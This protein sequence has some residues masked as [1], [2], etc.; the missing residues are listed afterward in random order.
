MQ[1][2]ETKEQALKA[3]QNR[4]KLDQLPKELLKQYPEICMEAVK[5]RWMNLKYVPEEVKKAHP[6]ICIEAMKQN[7]SALK[8]WPE[9]VQKKYLEL[10]QQAVKENG[11]LLEYLSEEIKKAHPD[12]CIE[13]VKQNNSALEYMPEEVQK[14]HPE[15]CQQ[16]VKEDGSLLKYVPEEVKKTH[17]DICAEAVK[18]Y[19][20]AIKYVPEEVQ[21]K[22]TELCGQAVK[23]DGELLEYISEEVKKTHPE[24]CLEA[25]KQSGDL[26]KYVPKDVMKQ[27]PKI[28][29]EATKD[30]DSVLEY[31]PDI[32]KIE[33]PQV[34][35]STLTEQGI[36]HKNYVPEC[37]Y[38]RVELEQGDN[39]DDNNYY[40]YEETESEEEAH[41]LKDN[42]IIEIL[43]V[44]GMLLKCASPE[45][46]KKLE[47]ALVAV[48]QN[49]NALAFVAPEIQEEVIK[50][51]KKDR[52]NSMGWQTEC[53]EEI[54]DQNN[55]ILCSPTGSG[56]T[57]VFLE[58]AKQK[59]T[60]PIFITSP[61][62]ALSNQ[63]YK[64]LLE[65]GF[66]V[67]IETGEIKNVPKNCD[68]ICCTQE[69]YTNKYTEQEDAT[70]IV[71]EF[72][73]IFENNDRARAYID[74]LHNSKAENILICS[75]T[76]GKLEE[77]QEYINKVTRKKVFF[78]Q[79]KRKINR[80]IFSWIHKQGKYTKFFSCCFFKGEL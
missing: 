58:W 22:K 41:Y 40:Y 3:L 66:V 44:D 33:Q 36:F 39:E 20:G 12:I 74:A 54:K 8:Y 57:T 76:L 71:D 70:L 7:N 51:L 31:I 52:S 79:W 19:E 73:Y 18:Q 47:I 34:L 5:K 60:K 42:Y 1:E 13:A 4:I 26:L 64:E 61:I 9:E 63:R 11:I 78:L 23:E 75:A 24:M 37:M 16:A 50:R 6:D 43:K 35:I 38:D 48:E 2:I 80:F 32:V 27:H 30:D 45:Q 67:G 25:V 72:H 69:I 46:R 15:L 62:K 59:G 29:I 77:L 10:C 21:K 56:K 68:F 17:P 55:V 65:K 14:E 53:L 49:E 28:C